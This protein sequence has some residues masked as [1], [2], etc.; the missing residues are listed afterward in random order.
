MLDLSECDLNKLYS[1]LSHSHYIN[2]PAFQNIKHH[3]INMENTKSKFEIEEILGNS[4][5]LIHNIL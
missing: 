1:I 5:D 2:H 4:N 3:L